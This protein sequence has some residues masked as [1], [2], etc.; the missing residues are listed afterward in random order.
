MADIIY[1]EINGE[2][3]ADLIALCNLVHEESGGMLIE[4]GHSAN[5]DDSARPWWAVMEI[6]A[7]TGEA[8]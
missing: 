1:Q 2:S 4:M 8:A 3:L 6:S 7:D 5:R